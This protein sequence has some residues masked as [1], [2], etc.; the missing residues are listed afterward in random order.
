MIFW[1]HLKCSFQHLN[2]V[3]IVQFA[4]AFISSIT[5]SWTTDFKTTSANGLVR[6]DLLNSWYTLNLLI[7]FSFLQC[8][9]ENGFSVHLQISPFRFFNV[10]KLCIII[11]DGLGLSWKNA[12]CKCSVY[13]CG[14]CAKRFAYERF[15]FYITFFK[16]QL[17]R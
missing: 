13:F 14:S 9:L 8:I 11:I 1:K 4:V 7:F 12:I 3:L 10:K 2:Y 6:K 17:K 16:Y 5:W 15:S